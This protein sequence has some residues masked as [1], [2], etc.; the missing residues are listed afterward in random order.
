M[1]TKAR[2]RSRKP[3]STVVEALGEN[4][5]RKSV[6]V[7]PQSTTVEVPSGSQALLFTPEQM[8]LFNALAELQD[9]VPYL[10]I[11]C[12]DFRAKAKGRGTM[13]EAGKDSTF[14]VLAGFTIENL[15]S[16]SWDME[17]AVNAVSRAL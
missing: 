10:Q 3:V 4:P 6:V 5:L 11:A 8:A 15:V 16:L 13:V 9:F 17:K 7:K 14:K 1:T 2:T 12:K